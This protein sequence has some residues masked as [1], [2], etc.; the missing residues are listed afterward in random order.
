MGHNLE[1]RDDAD[2]YPALILGDYVLGASS[3]SRL[4]DRLRQAEGLSYSVF[5][6]LSADSFER[7]GVFLAGAM[8]APQNAEQART[9]MLEEIERFRNDGPLR[10]ELEEAQRSY[11][12]G[13]DN[14]LAQDGYLAA[15]LLKTLHRGRTIHW[16]REQNERI[17]ALSAD[18]VQGAVAE[19][20]ESN[21]FVQ[22]MAGDLPP[23]E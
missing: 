14:R 5:S 17:A 3:K 2:V 19:R 23:S 4:L 6:T 20:I 18:D 11:Q 21:R 7:N 10:D 22:V 12:L 15:I 1:L 13:F 16:Y 8:C 9:A